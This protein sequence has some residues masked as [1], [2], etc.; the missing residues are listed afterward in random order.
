[1]VKQKLLDQVREALRAVG[2]HAAGK[3]DSP[4]PSYVVTS[5]SLPHKPI[6]S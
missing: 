5:F 1:M 3:G 4:K 6:S 2:G